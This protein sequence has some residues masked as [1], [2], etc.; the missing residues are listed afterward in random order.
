MG[1]LD[2]RPFLPEIRQPVLVLHGTEDRLVSM[3]RSDELMAGLPDAKRILLDGVGHQPHFTHPEELAR[4]VGD[5]CS[6]TVD[7]E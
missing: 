2:L 7:R 4:L 5:F 1:R 3:A 6:E